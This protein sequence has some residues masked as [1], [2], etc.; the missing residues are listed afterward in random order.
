MG[1]WGRSEQP[2]RDVANIIYMCLLCG[3]HG[4]RAVAALMES[5]FHR[6]YACA[7][8]RLLELRA[9][10]ALLGLLE[11]DDLRRKLVE[12]RTTRLKPLTEAARQAGA[13]RDLGSERLK[14]ATPLP[15][16]A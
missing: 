15:A 12:E 7:L 1:C 2:K 11:T 5:T 6:D 10:E 3:E 9:C 8:F 4:R 13:L 16:G 14:A